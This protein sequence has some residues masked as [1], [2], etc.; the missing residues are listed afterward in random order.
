MDFIVKMKFGSHLYGTATA[1]SDVDL[2]GVFL[3]TREVLERQ[4][5]FRRLQESLTRMAE[6]DRRLIDTGQFTPLSFPIM[7]NRLRTR[8]SSGKLADRVRRMQLALEKK[9]NR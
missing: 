2:K 8:I 4:L 5:E 9:A 1:Q 3:P 6:A 7:V